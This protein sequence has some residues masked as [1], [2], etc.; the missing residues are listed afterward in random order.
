MFIIGSPDNT[1]KSYDMYVLRD[2]EKGLM[3]VTGEIWMR[4]CQRYETFE[5]ASA[6]VKKF[7]KKAKKAYPHRTLAVMDTEGRVVT[8]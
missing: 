3:W 1:G 8:A 7:T 2:G 4:S 5:E 6:A